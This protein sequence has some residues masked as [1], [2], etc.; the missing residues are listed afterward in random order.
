[1]AENTKCWWECGA[2]GSSYVAHIKCTRCFGNHL[3]VLY[4][5]KHVRPQG[6]VGAVTAYHLSC[7]C[8]LFYKE[9]CFSVISKSSGSCLP[10]RGCEETAFGKVE[11]WRQVFVRGPWGICML[12]LRCEWEYPLPLS[13]NTQNYVSFPSMGTLEPHHGRLSLL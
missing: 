10:K 4:K 2:T 1:M 9:P 6:G 5:G 13:A 7:A 11:P 12:T 8:L 3:T